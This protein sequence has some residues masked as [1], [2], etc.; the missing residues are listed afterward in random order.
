ML[1]CSRPHSWIHVIRVLIQL[2]AI[3]IDC[4]WLNCT[5]TN[6]DSRKT[7]NEILLIKLQSIGIDKDEHAPPTSKSIVISWHSRDMFEHAIQHLFMKCLNLIDISGKHTPIRYEWYLCSAILMCNLSLAKWCLV[8]SWKRYT[9][10]LARQM[11]MNVADFRQH[12]L[13][14]QPN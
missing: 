6:D 12:L 8:Y 10:A 13:T 5:D 3:R 11:N 2:H 4:S 1:V 9:H 7:F 14:T